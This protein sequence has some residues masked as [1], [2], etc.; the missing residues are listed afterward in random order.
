[1]YRIPGAINAPRRSNR[2]GA[3]Y[4]PLALRPL[5]HA[6]TENAGT[7]FVA[8]FGRRN[9]HTARTPRKGTR[10]PPFLCCRHRS[11]GGLVAQAIGGPLASVSSVVGRSTSLPGRW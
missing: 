5:G 4:A 3:R 6:K 7:G 9:R 10:R 11:G 8:R 1:R 2:P